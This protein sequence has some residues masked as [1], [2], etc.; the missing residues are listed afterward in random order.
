MLN[1]N[2]FVN[3]KKYYIWDRAFRIN[4]ILNSNIYTTREVFSWMKKYSFDKWAIAIFITK[5]PVKTKS[6]IKRDDKYGDDS[7]F[8]KL[9]DQGDLDEISEYLRKKDS[10]DFDIGISRP[11][12]NIN[13]ELRNTSRDIKNKSFF[14][15]QSKKLNGILIEESILDIGEDEVYVFL[16]NRNKNDESRARQM[17][18]F[19]YESVI[20]S[21][22]SLKE[23]TKGAK[24]DAFGSIDRDFINEKAL[25]KNV[26][27]KYGGKIN[28]ISNFGDIPNSLKKDN[29]WSI[30]TNSNKSSSIDLADFRRISGLEIDSDGKIKKRQSN[31]Q[32]FMFVIG[33]HTDGIIDKEYIVHIRLENWSKYLPNLSDRN[34][35]HQIENMYKELPK[36]KLA[37][38]RTEETEREWKKFTNKY[39]AITND[40]PIK[41]SFKRDSKGQLRI[42]CTLTKKLFNDLILKDNDYIL[43]E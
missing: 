39:S 34:I 43:I 31:I 7:I 29:N 16:F 30:K 26:Y 3:E 1:F 22:L 24:W 19:V 38:K 40:K 8:G 14:D 42:Q 13:S 25:E 12:D 32:D 41:L 36:H 21:G 27:L 37:G 20:K 10:E 4:D 6:T 28:K 9:L 23:G 5:D 11:M 18:G 15:D 17:H 35:L 2:K 33:Y